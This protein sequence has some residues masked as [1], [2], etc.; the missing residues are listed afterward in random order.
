MS[1]AFVN[2]FWQR[3]ELKS[4]VMDLDFF[5]SQSCVWKKVDDSWSHV[6]MHVIFFYGQW[7]NRKLKWMRECAVCAMKTAMMTSD[8]L[9]HHWHVTENKISLK[10]GIIRGGRR[11]TWSCV[12]DSAFKEEMDSTTNHRYHKREWAYHLRPEQNRLEYCVSCTKV[13]CVS[14]NIFKNTS[15][16]GKAVFIAQYARTT[17][18]RTMVGRI[19]IKT[20]FSVI[21]SSTI[22]MWRYMQPKITC[23]L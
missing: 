16:I 23:K 14:A 19:S 2:G 20:T 17:E 21:S 18:K 12:A 10:N 9:W 8:G 15:L 22:L 5:W 1:R 3:S 7:K 13:S 11:W 4:W 6:K